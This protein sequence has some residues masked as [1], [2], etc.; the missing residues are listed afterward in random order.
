MSVTGARHDKEPY[1]IAMLTPCTSQVT[2]Y[3]FPQETLVH[4]SMWNV[5]WNKKMPLIYYIFYYSTKS[6]QSN[7]APFLRRLQVIT[8]SPSIGHWGDRDISLHYPQALACQKPGRAYIIICVFGGVWYGYGGLKFLDPG[9]VLD[10]H[11]IHLE[12]SCL[13]GTFPVTDLTFLR[14]YNLIYLLVWFFHVLSMLWFSWFLLCWFAFFGSVS[15]VG[16]WHIL[17]Y[18]LVVFLYCFFFNLQSLQLIQQDRVL[19][20]DSSFYF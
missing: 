9:L 12:P 17:A 6:H 18:F 4:W 16:I 13:D 14:L 1:I 2:M 11:H 19:L 5:K 3:G 7:Q 10:F 8:T 20:Q 15:S